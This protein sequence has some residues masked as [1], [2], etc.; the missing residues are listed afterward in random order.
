MF[1]KLEHCLDEHSGEYVRMFGIDK[2]SN[3]RTATTTIQRGDGKAVKVATSAPQRSSGS[4]SSS[5]GYSQSSSGGGNSSGNDEAAQVV[6]QI[7]RSGNKVGIEYADKRRYRSGIWQ[8]APSLKSGSESG[9]IAQLQ[10]FLS[11]HADKYVRVFG[12]NSQMKTRGSST[13]IQKPGQKS[14]QNSSS[15]S[16]QRQGGYDSSGK[17]PI[18]ANPPHYDDPAFRGQPAGLDAEMENKVSQLV[19]Q[20]HK[21]SIEYADKRRYRSGIWKTGPSISARRP[22]E[23]LSAL[24]QQLSQHQGE[25]VRLIGTDANA[26]RR[27]AEITIQRPGQKSS[28]NNGA[29]GSRGRKDP[30]NANPPHYDDPSFRGQPSSYSTNEYSAKRAGGGGGYGNQSNGN[31]NGSGL[32]SKVLDQVTQ[33]VNQGHKISLEYA[34]KRRYR[35][36]IWKTGQAIDARRPA[37]AIS[38]LGKQLARHEG[39]YVR[40]IGTDPN[41][42]RRVLE[43][44]IQRP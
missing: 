22:A 21:I 10:Q 7:I 41:A 6:S 35:S 27:V 15:Q 40:L 3:S 20:G 19:S 34:D 12:V 5:S 29:A 38:A 14:S 43:A 39:E 24:N 28:S 1:A 18:N 44:T 33:L 30:I 32:E 17:D 26:K 25:Y 36:G 9:A 2:S 11:Q 16:R 31:N 13:T 42:K 4:S 37:E 8:T 23:A